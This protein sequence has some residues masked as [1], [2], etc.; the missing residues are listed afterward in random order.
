M[1]LSLP[2]GSTVIID[3]IGTVTLFDSLFLSNVL[4]TPTFHFNLISVSALTHINHYVVNFYSDLCVIQ[5]LTRDLT[6]GKGRRRGN[7]YFLDLGT[8]L[9]CFLIYTVKN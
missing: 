6:I 3:R 7:L 4:Y 5:E 2:N 8:Q 9:C 1:S